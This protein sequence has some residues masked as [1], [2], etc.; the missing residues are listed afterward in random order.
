MLLS[1]EPG[2]EVVAEADDGEA[3]VEL[4]RRHAPDVVLIDLRMPNVDGVTAT[5]ELTGDDFTAVQGHT[6]KVL[7]LTTFQEP[8]TV[9]E[10]LCAGAS[11]FLLK[12]SVPTE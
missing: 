7:V 10:A 12:E 2:I 5:R 3:A 4:A 9:C 11:G 1:Q 6:V 8:E